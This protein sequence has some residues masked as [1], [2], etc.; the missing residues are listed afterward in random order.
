MAY[1][2][3]SPTTQ[4]GTGGGGNFT[5]DGVGI[6]TTSSLGIHTNALATN[7]ALTGIGYSFQ[8]LYVANGMMIVDNQLNGNHYI[9]TNF[10]GV[11]PGPVTVNGLLTVDGHY[12]VV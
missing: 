10:N 2:G 7:T 1:I 12:V 9:G 6:H 5:V 3:Y 4:A 11:M 8:G